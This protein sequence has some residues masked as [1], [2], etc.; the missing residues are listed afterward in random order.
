MNR[1]G[2]LL[3]LI[4]I[5]MLTAA[6]CHADGEGKHGNYKRPKHLAVS[7]DAPQAWREE[8]AACHLA[9]PPGLLP[10]EA[11]RM[12]M[13]DLSDHYG[14]DAS[15]DPETES[16]ILGYLLKASTDNRLPRE[17]GRPGNPPRIT[18][19]RWFL[20]KHDDISASTFRRLDIGSASNC[21]AC[22]R[23]AERGDFDEDRVSIPKAARQGT[24]EASVVQQNPPAEYTSTRPAAV[25]GSG[26]SNSCRV[27]TISSS[28][29]CGA[30]LDAG[31]EPAAVIVWTQAADGTW[32]CVFNGAS[33]TGLAPESCTNQ[34]PR[35]ALRQESLILP[36]PKRSTW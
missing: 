14:S 21:A 15:L 2:L 6:G 27:T 24:Q 31:S 35:Q 12:Q 4:L 19:T 20:K 32:A 23:D 34:E 16:V 13:Q 18:E 8:C 17:G 22:H 3:P 9:Y 30:S 25:N 28:I 11:W 33:D 5:P 36:G 7:T 10:A 26:V 29:H 1:K